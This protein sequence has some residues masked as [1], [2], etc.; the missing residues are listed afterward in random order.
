MGRE[1]DDHTIMRMDGSY[2]ARAEICHGGWWIVVFS[3]GFFKKPILS[4]D[5]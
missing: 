5:R 2:G 4:K 3:L 1:S